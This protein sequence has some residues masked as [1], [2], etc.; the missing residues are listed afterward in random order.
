MINF[1]ISDIR[2][3]TKMLAPTADFDSS[4]TFYYDETNNIRKFYVREVDF[5]SSFNSNFVLGGLVYEGTQPKIKSL[6]D[7]FNLQNNIKEVK[8]KHIAKGNF[9]DCLKSEELNCFLTYLLDSDLYIHYSS[10]NILYWSIVDIVDSAIA[11]SE[12]AM[13]LGLD[14]SNYLKNDLYKLAKLEIES[15]IELFYNSE[16]PNLKKEAVLEFIEKLTSIFDEY[17]DT[18]EFHFGLESLRQ[19]LKQAGKKDSLPLVMDEEN[20]ILI[21]DFSQFYLRPIYLFENSNHIFDNEVAISEILANHR[22]IND[23]KE[24]KNYS[25]VD[26]QSNLFV[27]VSDIFVGLIGKL[28]NYIN[29]NSAEKIIDDL[30]SL[31]DKQLNNINSLIDLLNKSHSRNIAF[32]HSIDSYEELTK[33]NLIREIRDK[34]HA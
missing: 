4:F 34:N 26:S 22:I 23:N 6:F 29:T 14:F 21:E 18:A 27:Q 2:K 8:L 1:E 31:S 33:M 7:G 17:I 20:Y 3:M 24:I 10:L 25:F 30:N 5:N 32:L 12:V 11:N 16:Y 13:Q 19:I 28:A 15:V 9:L